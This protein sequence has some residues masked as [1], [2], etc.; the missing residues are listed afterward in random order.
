MRVKKHNA[1]NIVELGD[2]ITSDKNRMAPRLE[3]I[4]NYLSM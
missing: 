2:A 4:H 3:G 1:I